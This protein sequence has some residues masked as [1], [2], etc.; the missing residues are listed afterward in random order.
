MCTMIKKNL[1]MLSIFLL[2][3]M[4]TYADTFDKAPVA[5]VVEYTAAHGKESALLNI[6]QN[7]AR[8]TLK[9]EPG[10]LFFGVLRPVDSKGSSVPDRILLTE[11]YKDKEAASVHANN[12][13]LPEFRKRI[14]PLLASE[15]VTQTTVLTPVMGLTQAKIY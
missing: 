14:I 12:P 9:E 7:H 6:L 3:A 4:S 5:I 2:P 11:F 13:R 10:C 15:K 8:L 1:F